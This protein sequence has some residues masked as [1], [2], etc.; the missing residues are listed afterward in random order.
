MILSGLL[1]DRG[2]LHGDGFLAT[3]FAVLGLLGAADCVGEGVCGASAKRP[4]LESGRSWMELGGVTKT[5]TSFLGEGFTG[6]FF[7]G[8]LTG[9]F[10][11]LLAEFF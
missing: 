1:V 6:D 2:L 3:L 9:D 5:T 8:D 4:N 10:Q 11:F 7:L